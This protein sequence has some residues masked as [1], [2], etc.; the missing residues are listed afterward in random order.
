MPLCATCS[1]AQEELRESSSIP[2]EWQLQV[3]ADGS[4]SSS[5]TAAVLSCL[6]PEAR[7][8]AQAAIAQLPQIMRMFESRDQGSNQHAMPISPGTF[9]QGASPAWASS[10]L[11]SS[12]SQFDSVS[13]M[14]A[15]AEAPYRGS[16]V[17]AGPQ[18]AFNTLLQPTPEFLQ[19][20]PACGLPSSGNNQ[21][22][23]GGV[24]MVAQ[25]QPGSGQQG[26]LL[27]APQ[28]LGA[29]G[30][31]HAYMQ[32]GGLPPGSAVAGA[33]WAAA[34]PPGVSGSSTAMVGSPPMVPAPASMLAP[35]QGGMFLQHQA[36]PTGPMQP[37]PQVPQGALMQ[38]PLQQQARNL[39]P[40]G[41]QLPQQQPAASVPLSSTMLMHLQQV[42]PQSQSPA[43]LHQAQILPGGAGLACLPPPGDS[44]SGDQL[45]QQLQAL[46]LTT[47][48]MSQQL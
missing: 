15:Q 5:S 23:L 16:P 40:P 33:S 48:A 43:Q 6:P 20:G 22:G 36:R 4:I 41:M 27:V 24:M 9:M 39:R 31:P 10:S 13:G 42:Q 45:L 37:Y 11:A 3:L 2:D 46:G 47:V 1:H 19:Y 8:S 32:V 25:Q 30:A 26:V 14:L 38:P 35:G 18:H 7:G 12:G 21:Q 44:A 34:R 28:Q 29:A 17:V